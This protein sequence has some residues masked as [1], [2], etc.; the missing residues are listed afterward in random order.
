MIAETLNWPAAAVY[1]TVV[2]GTLS[3]LAFLVWRCTRE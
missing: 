1:I 3:F 2:V